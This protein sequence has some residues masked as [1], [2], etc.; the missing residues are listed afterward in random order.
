M[1]IVQ[2]ATFGQL[3]A[4][5]LA[6]QIGLCASDKVRVASDVNEAQERLI[7]DPR[8]PDEGWWGGWGTFRYNVSRAAPTITTPANVA[9][10][11]VMD[12]CK[13]PVPIR[14]EFYEFLEFGVG[15]QPKGCNSTCQQLQAYEREM[16]VTMADLVPPAIIRIFPG[17]DSDVGKTVLIQ[18]QDSNGQTV[19]SKDAAGSPYLGERL[20]LA[21]PFT[22]SANYYSVL[23]GIQKDVTGFPVTFSQVN[24]DTFV[25]TSLSHM[26]PNETTAQ[27]RKYY[28][29][30]LPNRCCNTT[31]T[32]IQ[33]IAK[34]K[35]DFVPVKNEEDYLI[36]QCIPALIREVQAM[37]DE[38]FDDGNALDRSM[39]RHALALSLL[40]GELD[41]FMGKYRPSIDVP[42]FGRRRLLTQRI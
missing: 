1:S 37:R 22:D 23:T 41:S 38:T 19:I 18:G 20:T 17:D 31:S 24:P 34:G 40:F 32:Q 12:V 2:R 5:R 35:L 11:I 6:Q 8:A 21:V 3:L 10:L 4:S 26:E 15:F 16:V 7:K 9:R 39:K 30:G 29:N 25:E 13:T 27:Y 28:I 33:V 36:I 42:L 14:N